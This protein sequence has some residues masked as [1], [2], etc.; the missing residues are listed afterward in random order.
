MATSDDEND[1]HSE[2][3]LPRSTR[4][5]DLAHISG[6]FPILS[7]FFE[8]SYACPLLNAGLH[9]ESAK[10]KNDANDS[11]DMF[12]ATDK[13]SS[14]S[15]VATAGPSKDMG[16]SIDAMLGSSF[17]I[18][19]V[20]DIASGFKEFQKQGQTFIALSNAQGRIEFCPSLST[21]FWCL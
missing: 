3:V 21:D 2:S 12:D 1:H 11:L 5:S 4:P 9:T 15:S 6:L 13:D 20:Q 14:A 17:V 18:K 7:I 10:E 19:A 8:K 16:V